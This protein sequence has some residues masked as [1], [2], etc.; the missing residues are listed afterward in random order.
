MRKAGLASLAFFYFDF[1]EDGKT[2][3][4][5]LLSSLLAQ[6][7]HQSDPYCE[8][9]S[10]FYSEHAEGLRR[11]SNT[12]LVECLKDLLSFPGLAPVYLI[13][14]AL[15]ECPNS[16]ATP[17]PRG[18]VLSLI[19]ELIELQF[20][21]LHI[22]VTSRPESDIKVVLD[23]L[24]SRYISLHDQGGHK[25]D[26]EDYIRSFIN[27]HPTTRKWKL[28]DKQLVIGVLTRKADGMY[29]VNTKFSMTLAYFFDVGLDGYIVSW[30]TS[31]TSSQ[32][33][34]GMHLPTYQRRWTKHMGAP[35]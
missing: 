35:C 23:P 12:E 13:V 25:R 24:I 21:N 32:H 17:S 28:E 10:D 5:G 22:C 31:A 14:D 29:G 20:P 7:G 15:D 3:L 11:P 2:G 16:S 6:L 33:V 4:R 27:T 19:E 18:E 26:I 34:S 1:R 9:L 30:T 8:M